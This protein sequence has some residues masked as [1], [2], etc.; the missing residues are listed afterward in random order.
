MSVIKLNTLIGKEQDPE[1]WNGDILGDPGVLGTL[2][3]KFWRT[4]INRDSCTTSEWE[5]SFYFFWIKCNASPEVID[6]QDIVD[7]LQDPFSH[8]SLYLDLHESQWFPK[9]KVQHVTHEEACY[10]T[11]H[12][13]S[14]PVYRDE[15]LWTM[16][17]NRC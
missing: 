9:G 3:P 2:N 4:F 11:K 14:S 16:Y 7:S 6:L 10:N 17:G 5:D 15:K 8:S 12:Y 13:V 1:N